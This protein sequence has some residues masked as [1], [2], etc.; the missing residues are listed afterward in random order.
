MHKGPGVLILDPPP[1]P[2]ILIQ[3]DILIVACFMLSL[4]LF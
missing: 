4:K 3:D 1:R 2:L